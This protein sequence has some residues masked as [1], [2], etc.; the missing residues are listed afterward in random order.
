MNFDYDHSF[1][2]EG[3]AVDRS[4]P[5]ARRPL[6]SN[7]LQHFSSE[8][9]VGQISYGRALTVIDVAGRVFMHSRWIYLKDCRELGA[10]TEEGRTIELFQLNSSGGRERATLVIEV[11]CKCGAC[12]AGRGRGFRRLGG[13]GCVRSSGVRSV[14]AVARAIGCDARFNPLGHP[15]N[16]WRG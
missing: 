7:L 8:Q 6:A 10:V 13:R 16:A 14:V 5:S 3:H 11:E 2:H 1:R 15:H 12:V 9:F 4:L